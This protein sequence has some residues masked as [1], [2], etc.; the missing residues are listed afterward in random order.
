MARQFSVRQAAGNTLAPEVVLQL[1]TQTAPSADWQIKQFDYRDNVPARIDVTGGVL[2]EI[3]GWSQAL[4]AQG[5]SVK[6]ENARL[7]N[8]I[9]QATLHVASM[10]GKR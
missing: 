5:V 3:N 2:D 6:V 9:A 8:G 7:D 10:G 4:E 1:V